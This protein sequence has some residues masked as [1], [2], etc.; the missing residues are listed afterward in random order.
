MS[1]AFFLDREQSGSFFLISLGYFTIIPK[2]F[3]P[4]A[5]LDHVGDLLRIAGLLTFL[6]AML[7]GEPTRALDEDSIRSARALL[8]HRQTLNR[9]PLS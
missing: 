3:Q 5:T 4:N 9:G 8:A 6:A 2:Y 1:G 7:V